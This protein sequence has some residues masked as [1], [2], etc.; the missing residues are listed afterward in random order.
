MPTYDYSCVK[1]GFVQEEMHSVSAVVEI[2]CKKCGSNSEK[3]FSPNGSFILSGNDWPSTNFRMK[4][5]MLDKNA[6]M[7]SKMIDKTHAGE[8]VTKVS[9]LKK[10]N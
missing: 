7:K 1:C 2:K 5:A 9:D 10:Y 3:Q 4:K 6:R 8:A